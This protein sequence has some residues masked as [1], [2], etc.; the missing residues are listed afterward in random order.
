MPDRLVHL[1]ETFGFRKGEGK[2]LAF[3]DLFFTSNLLEVILPV[4]CSKRKLSLKRKKKPNE[5]KEKEILNFFIT[6]Q[7]KI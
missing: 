5:T 2:T 3:L 4:R 7:L 1:L 6:N